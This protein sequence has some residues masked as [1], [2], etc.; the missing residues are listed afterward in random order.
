MPESMANMWELQP[1]EQIERKVLQAQFGGRTQGGIGPSKKTPNV[2]VFSDP[3]AG[4]P[5]G[6]F[7]GWRSDRFFH[8]TG[9]GQRGDQRMVSGNASILRHVEEDRALRLFMG[10]RGTVQY[11]G[12]FELED[13]YTTEAP[14]TGGGP[15]RTVIVFRLQPKDIEPKSHSGPLDAVVAGDV[16]AFIPVEEQWTEK[17]FVNPSREPIEAERREQTL[18]LAYRDFLRRQGHSVSRNKIVP[19]GEHKPL[20]TDLYDQTTSTLYEAKGTVTRNAIRTAIGQ[21]ADYKRFIPGG[22]KAL[23]VLLPS[24]PRQDLLE[25]LHAE[26]V[27]AVWPDETATFAA[28]RNG[29]L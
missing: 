3:V 23:A 13:W 9:E 17:T 28:S 7:D 1:G 14:E 16:H 6:Y 2:F 20:F 18:V 5:H 27:T 10:A 26:D 8:Y 12:E 4:E 24:E 25:L 22:P 29:V 19:P 15:V 21:L 11:E